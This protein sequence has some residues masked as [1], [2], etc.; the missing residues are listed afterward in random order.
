MG[1][2]PTIQMVAD[3]AG[4]SRGTVDRV[5]NNR[6]YVKPE[7]RERVLDAIRKTEYLS[8]LQAHE[9]MVIRGAFA[10]IRL[11]VLLPNWTG[12]FKTEILRGVVAAREELA[13]FHV[14]ILIAECK[15]DIPGEVIELLEQLEKQH[16]QGIALCAIDDSSIEA[17]IAKLEEAHIPV[18]TLNSDLPGSRRLCFVGQDYTQSGRI[19]GELMSK[20]IPP[21]G[22]LLALVGNLEFDGHRKRLQGFLQRMQELDFRKEQFEIIETYNDY[23]T[24][25]RKVSEALEQ[26]P[27][28]CSIYMANQSIAGCTEAVHAAGKKGKL[29]IICHD[30]SESTKRLLADGNID[31]TI[32][33]DIFRQGYLPLILLREF[34]Q[35]NKLPD[36]D[37]TS[38]NISIIC[39]QNMENI[40]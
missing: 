18:I 16:V 22:K 3:L 11:G 40:S 29:R 13:D 35:K 1:K 12:H 33:Q 10:P 21:N 2:R 7:V 24:T 14:D 17:K 31:F 23:Q 30:I 26:Y 8:P 37:Q 39:S 25:R 32:S 5:L 4:V 19:A 28:L 20:C 27:K 15:T 6:S 34:L 36:F 38:T 9:R